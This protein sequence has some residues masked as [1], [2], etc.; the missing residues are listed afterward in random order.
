M[1]LN[2]ILHY[3]ITTYIYYSLKGFTCIRKK[4]SQI[5]FLLP[6]VGILC[7]SFLPE[8]QLFSIQILRPRYLNIMR[9]IRKTTQLLVFQFTRIDVIDA[10]LRNVFSISAT[11]Y[12]LAT[13]CHEFLFLF[14]ITIALTT[15]SL[16][17]S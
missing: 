12:L 5:L 14:K 13:F 11:I 7:E 17:L 9:Y 3:L 1:Y 15:N 16:F 8:C 4:I 2:K 6:T 10:M